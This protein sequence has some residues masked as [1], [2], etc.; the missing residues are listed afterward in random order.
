M[1]VYMCIMCGQSLWRSD[2]VVRFPYNWI[3]ELPY[4]FGFS[5]RAAS[6]LKC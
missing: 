2:K 3:S 5:A 1:Y 6:T 4:G